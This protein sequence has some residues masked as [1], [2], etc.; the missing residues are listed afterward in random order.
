[1]INSLSFLTSLETPSKLSF[2]AEFSG[3]EEAGDSDVEYT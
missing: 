3:E 1:M 2:S